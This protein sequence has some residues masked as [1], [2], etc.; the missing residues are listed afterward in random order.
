MVVL[1]YQP[2]LGQL[3][4]QI[5]KN[6]SFLPTLQKG[7]YWDPVAE[8]NADIASIGADPSQPYWIEWDIT[9]SINEAVKNAPSLQSPLQSS[10]FGILAFLSGGACTGQEYINFASQRFGFRGFWNVL[11]AVDY[12]ATPT[13]TVAG[14]VDVISTRLS[15]GT[16]SADSCCIYAQYANINNIQ[17][18]LSFKALL[19]SYDGT[20]TVTDYTSLATEFV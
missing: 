1:A 20:Y 17:L 11:P 8:I 4:G 18:Y 12:P 15:T 5:Q 13:A 7:H 10:F 2:D 14:E 9:V 6:A 19:F 3:I 16:K